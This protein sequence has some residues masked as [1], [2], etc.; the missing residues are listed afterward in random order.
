MKSCPRP[1][2]YFFKLILLGISGLKFF[3]FSFPAQA[4]TPP[5]VNPIPN[6]P[7]VMSDWANGDWGNPDFRHQYTDQNGNQQVLTGHPEWGPVGGWWDF[8]D[9]NAR[10][11]PDRINPAS[12]EEYIKDAK[13]MTVTLDNGQKIPKPVGVGI[14]FKDAA[15]VASWAQRLNNPEFDNLAF[16]VALARKGNQGGCGNNYGEIEPACDL[17][18]NEVIPALAQHFPKIPVFF[19]GTV[20]TLSGICEK[21]L[22]QAN[23]NVGAKCNGWFLDLDNAQETVNGVLSGGSMR[24]ADVYYDRLAVG[25][26]PKAG[27]ST[28]EWYWGLMDALSHHPDILDIQGPNL[29]QMA[30]FKTEYKFPLLEFTRQYLGKTRETA[31]GAWVVFRT[32]K[33]GGVCGCGSPPCPNGT[34]YKDWAKSCCTQGGRECCWT[35]GGKN[36]CRGPQKINYSYWL[37]QK[38]EI[39]GG[40]TKLIGIEENPFPSIPA[41]NHPYSLYPARQ[42]DQGTGNQSIYFDIDDQYSASTNSQSWTIKAVF[43]NQGTDKL[44]LE[45][46]N[47]SGQT[48]KKAINKGS[49]LGP[50][51]NWVEYQWD[52]ND[53]DFSGNKMGG[54]DF[55]LDSENDGLDEIIHRVMVSPG[56]APDGP[57]PNSPTQPPFWM[58]LKLGKIFT[59]SQFMVK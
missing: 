22:N 27:Q 31:P 24:F 38:D 13:T 1:K 34:V 39:A 42:T 10:K 59:G 26:E 35:S 40:Q 58:K 5:G 47:K 21:S 45:Y 19:Q 56:S 44:T 17:W 8:S 12:P 49:D 52:L 53:A 30:S 41:K 51:D 18:L 37:Y 15:D 55:R 4:I 46:I 36:I 29:S 50:V 33:Q 20:N 14:Q 43:V 57:S 3:F 28:E 9:G 32:T 11:L 54:A 7:F 2:K 16:I 23:K 48:I 6:I 25:Y